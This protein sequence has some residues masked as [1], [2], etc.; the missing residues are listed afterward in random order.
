[1]ADRFAGAPSKNDLYE[2]CLDSD[3][4]F[5]SRK[6][7]KKHRKCYDIDNMSI[8]EFKLPPGGESCDES[9]YDQN[10]RMEAMK[11][12]RAEWSGFTDRI[13]KVKIA[14]TLFPAEVQQTSSAIIGSHATMS[15]QSNQSL[16]LN[17]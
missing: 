12:I 1:M 8:A 14:R 9:N 7:S 15:L 11:E 10:Q 13:S 4:D 6:K 2:C 16:M 5:S 3:S 17:Q